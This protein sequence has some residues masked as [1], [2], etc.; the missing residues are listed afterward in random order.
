MPTGS[1]PQANPTSWANQSRWSSILAPEASASR[2]EQASS[3]WA[4]SVT[5]TVGAEPDKAVASCALGVLGFGVPE[6][7]LL[8]LGNDLAGLVPHADGDVTRSAF[9]HDLALCGA[10]GQWFDVKTEG[11]TVLAFAE[12]RS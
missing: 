4:A 10:G 1:A 6:S 2:A 8:M 5:V 7:L 3:S 11:A 12:Q 9:P